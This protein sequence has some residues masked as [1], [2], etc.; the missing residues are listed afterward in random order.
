MTTAKE[1]TN[2]ILHTERFLMDLINPKKTP[3]V[4]SSIRAHARMLL[5]HY[6]T[7]FD[8]CD[9]EGRFEPIAEL[10]YER[11]YKRELE[12]MFQ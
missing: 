7:Q 2:S 11:D 10:N 8:L 9:L 1:R 6:P 4:P 3:R 5:R 12:E